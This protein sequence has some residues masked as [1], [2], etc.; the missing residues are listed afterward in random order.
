MRVSGLIIDR[1]ARDISSIWEGPSI[2]ANLKT[3]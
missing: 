3:F 2:E 1:M